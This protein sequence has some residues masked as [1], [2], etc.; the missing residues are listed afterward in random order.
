MTKKATGC[1]KAK[2]VDAMSELLTPGT[3]KKVDEDQLPNFGGTHWYS[4]LSTL[5][6]ILK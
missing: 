4:L 3:V 6:K 1:T 5:R 2:V